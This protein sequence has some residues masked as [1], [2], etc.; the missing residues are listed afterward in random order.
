M[1]LAAFVSLAAVALTLV[2]VVGVHARRANRETH[3]QFTQSL[4]ELSARLDGLARELAYSVEKVRDEGL[5]ARILGSLGRTLDLDEVLT[6]CAEAAA[7]LSGVAAAAVTVEI[8]GIRRVAAVGVDPDAIDVSVGPPG[9]AAVRAVAL[10]YHYREEHRGAGAMLSAIAVPIG[11]ADR[12][13]GFLTV[14]GQD[15]EPPV[16]GAE[17]RTLEA[18]AHHVGPA[19]EKAR[20]TSTRKPSATDATGLANRELLHKTLA[21]EVARTQRSGRKL[22]VCLLDVDDLRAANARLGQQAADALLA[23]I[24]S[25]LR[26]TIRPGDLVFRSGGDAFVVVLPDAGRIEAEATFA[27]VQASLRRLPRPVTMGFAPSLSAG[28][29]E[30][31]PDDD[32]VSLFERAERALR[33]AKE[34]G[35]GTAA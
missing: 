34:A 19:I 22:A 16:A 5:R 3:A 31:K 27:R 9:G 29:A 17:F 23:E 33:R 8:D 21:L 18:I 35:K 28:I 20:Q 6:R 24:T 12:R 10:S 2:G 14:Y 7:S 30:V 1:E 11:L 4:L 25:L 13:L 26:A 15:E 32:G